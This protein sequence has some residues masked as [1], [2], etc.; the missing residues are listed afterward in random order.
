MFL[1]SVCIY[2][3]GFQIMLQACQKKTCRKK[4]RDFKL[5][6]G[7]ACQNINALNINWG[8]NLQA[9][10]LSGTGQYRYVIKQNK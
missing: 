3:A 2:D 5:Y 4:L 7:K 1:I 8:A 9:N 6:Y 10:G